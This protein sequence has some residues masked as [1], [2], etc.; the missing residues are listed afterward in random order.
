MGCNCH[1]TPGNPTSEIRSRHCVSPPITCPRTLSLKSTQAYRV[2]SFRVHSYMQNKMHHESHRRIYVWEAFYWIQQHITIAS[3]ARHHHN[4]IQHT[5]AHRHAT[6]SHQAAG[7]HT[8]RYMN[9]ACSLLTQ[10]QTSTLAQGACPLLIDSKKNGPPMLTPTNMN[11]RVRSMCH[12]LS[13][14]IVTQCCCGR[15]Q[16]IVCAALCRV[17]TSAG[18]LIC[19]T[20]TATCR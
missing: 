16:Q 9:A 2:Q 12:L 1:R 7:A 11:Y 14:S 15:K 10:P 18:C 13:L 3:P 17:V 8:Y 6:C 4:I 20:L 19:H 5:A